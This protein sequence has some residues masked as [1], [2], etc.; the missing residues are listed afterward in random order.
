MKKRKERLDKLL[1]D[2]GLVETRTRAQALIMGGLV[3]VDG[4]KNDKSGTSIDIESN[5]EIRNMEEN[6][7]SRGAYKLIKA[8]DSFSLDVKDRICIDV[9]A[10]TGGFTDVL[11]SRGASMVYAVDV[12]YGQL[13]WK[14]RQD[15]RVVVMER[16][17]ARYL[18]DISFDPVPEIAVMDA[19]FISAKLL[20]PAIELVI[21]TGGSVISLIKP[22]FEAGRERIGKG[23]V[24]RVPEIHLEILQEMADFLMERTS[25]GLV[26]VDYSPIKGPKGNIEFLFH[27]IKGQSPLDFDLNETVLSAHQ[28]DLS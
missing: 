8:L 1:V 13:H 12:G 26:G 15:S 21:P 7:V 20:L 16:T 2:R 18:S 11:L 24:V 19:S 17:N 5:L 3:Y 28:G 6:W 4:E 23:G 10:S 22:Q 25:L 9:G 14:L 27:M